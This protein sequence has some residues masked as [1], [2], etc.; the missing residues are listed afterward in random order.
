M[1]FK[2]GHILTKDGPLS[3]DSELSEQEF[4]DLVGMV[5]DRWTLD[6]EAGEKCYPFSLPLDHEEIIFYPGSFS[7]WHEGH[8]ACVRNAPAHLPL[9]VMPDHNPWKDIRKNNLWSEVRGIWHD[10]NNIKE[11]NP[12]RELSLYLGFLSLKKRNPT[13][14]WMRYFCENWPNKKVWLLM[15]EDTF[16]SLHEWYRA[17]ELLSLLHGLYV[18]PRG[19]SKIEVQKQMENLQEMAQKPLLIE[20]LASHAFEH[21][22]STFLRKSR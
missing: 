22:S 17:E 5:M 14:S 1:N 12:R 8:G 18:C 13:V 10:L 6:L 2:D 3:P 16:L 11:K 15:G 19:E 9:I 7:P 21:I 20:E 4:E